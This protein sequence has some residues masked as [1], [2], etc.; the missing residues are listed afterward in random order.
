METRINPIM[1]GAQS[2]AE[3]NSQS[4]AA[5]PDIHTLTWMAGSWSGLAD[6]DPVDE[7]WS[8][9]AG[10]MMMG[11]FRWLKNERVYYYELLVIEPASSGLVLRLKHFDTGLNGWEEKGMAVAYPLVHAS[12]NEAVFERGGSFRSTRFVYRRINAGELLVT[13][14]DRKGDDIVTC[15]FRYTRA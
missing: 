1:N 2:A 12:E 6:G 9:P 14:H 11:M 3:T 13:T 7:H 5:I 15:E 4:P 8:S 10:G